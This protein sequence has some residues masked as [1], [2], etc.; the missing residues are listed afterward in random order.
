MQRCC[1][2]HVHALRWAAGLEAYIYMCVCRTPTYVCS[3]RHGAGCTSSG[4]TPPLGR[5]RVRS[6]S[7]SAPP[8]A[9]VVPV[10]R[11]GWELRG[12]RVLRTSSTAVHPD[13]LCAGRAEAG[14]A[15]LPVLSGQQGE[16][17]CLGS[18]VRQ[19]AL[20][21]PPSGDGLTVRPTHA[22]CT[23]QLGPAK[24]ASPSLCV[25]PP[26]HSRCGA[27]GK[28]FRGPRPKAQ[29]RPK[30][31]APPP[32]LTPPWCDRSRT[33]GVRRM[34]ATGAS[35]PHRRSVTAGGSG[36]QGGRSCDRPCVD[37][38]CT[39]RHRAHSTSDRP[40]RVADTGRPSKQERQD[41]WRRQ[42]GKKAQTAPVREHQQGVEGSRARLAAAS[43]KPGLP[44]P[45]SSLL[46]AGGRVHTCARQGWAGRARD[47]RAFRATRALTVRGPGGAPA[48]G[49]G[50]E[51]NKK[52]LEP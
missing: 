2:T 17:D 24:A 9:A 12:R 50:A 35:L 6:C 38:P 45:G 43:E 42:G 40:T 10:C 34:C 32:T 5:E 33:Q 7:A 14:A 39:G 47:S 20:K 30:N 21:L 1:A 3:G 15:G 29:K 25:A 22:A 36:S 11:E 8:V 44:T 16:G 19:S 51:E 31:A 49:R 27:Q 28:P 13:M 18:K 37:R 26:A 48:P 4:P 41:L 46:G 23:R 52:T